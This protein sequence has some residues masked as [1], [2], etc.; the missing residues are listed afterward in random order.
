MSLRPFLDTSAVH[1]NDE[2]IALLKADAAPMECIECDD[3]FIVCTDSLLCKYQRED[4]V[5]TLRE[6]GFSEAFIGLAV[7]AGKMG[8]CLIR[9]EA[10]EE[11]DPMLPIDRP[12]IMEN[13][14]DGNGTQFDLF[15][16]NHSIDPK[17]GRYL[18]RDWAEFAFIYDATPAEAR[19]WPVLGL[20]GG[21][22]HWQ[23]SAGSWIW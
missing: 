13:V 22:N 20:K 10:G 18:E 5:I 8:A 21:Q 14:S 6:I 4:T 19:Y 2:G 17:A 23:S 16:A 9:F 15:E 12:D 11:A 1:L 3:G 7:H